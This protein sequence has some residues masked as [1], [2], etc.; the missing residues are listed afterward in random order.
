MCKV[1]FRMAWRWK[2]IDIVWSWISAQ[3][4]LLDII[5]ACYF[6]HMSHQRSHPSALIGSSFQIV[7]SSSHDED[8]MTCERDGFPTSYEILLLTIRYWQSFQRNPIFLT[9]LF[10][11]PASNFENSN[12]TIG[13]YMDK[14]HMFLST[15][16]G[17]SSFV[18]DRNKI[19]WH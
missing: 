5:L 8:N 2:P 17:I 3:D 7:L 15:R 4:N 18:N 9:L 16:T 6:I 10:P 14:F 19:Q 1:R 13:I 12:K 11:I